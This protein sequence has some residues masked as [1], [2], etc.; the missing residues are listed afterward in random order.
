MEYIINYLL[1]S[2][3]ILGVLT[4]FYRLVLHHE[5]LFKFNRFYLLFSLLMATVVP[6]IHIS[7][8]LLSSSANETVGF[9]N[10]LET[11]N[12]FSD[13]VRK[14]V[15][16]LIVKSKSF[17]W[18]YLLGAIGLLFRLLLGVV[19]L[20]G[21][22]KKATWVQIKGMQ[23]ADLPG[24]FN[25]FSFFHVI[26]IN[27][28]LY[29]DDDLDKI[30]VHEMAHVKHRHSIDVL[31]FELLLVIQWFNPFAWLTKYLLKELHEF[32]ADRSVL[33][34]GA[35]VGSYKNLLLYQATGARL[36]P[37]NN[38][39][40]SITKKRFKMMTNKTIKNKAFIKTL[41]ASL[42]LVA[43]G[44]FSSF[45]S[46]QNVVVAQNVVK[47][48]EKE[49]VYDIVDVMPIF[50]GGNDELMKFVAKN[51]KYPVDAQEHGKQGKV[52]IQFV[53]S[54]TGDVKDIEVLRTAG[55][56]SIDKEAI[57][58]VK[59]MPKWTPGMHK[60]KIVNVEYTMPV[61]FVIYDGDKEKSKEEVKPQK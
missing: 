3:I 9:V 10:L 16:P 59:L 6:L 61:N 27:R 57:R 31:L 39:N 12:V 30:L 43:I 5:P 50:P 21:L 35:S 26:F 18:L 11:V 56:E 42:M 13:D 29:S 45:D 19:R 53:V 55:F 58:V 28:S 32:Q 46:Y 24:R 52:F 60:G 51:V 33:N 41:A 44:L 37:V 4:I 22:S 54:K 34:K 40:Q 49:K 15:V 14:S 8:N 36:L 20:G 48:V 2:S 38:F 25:P 17:G 47:V 7:F 1:E 23:I